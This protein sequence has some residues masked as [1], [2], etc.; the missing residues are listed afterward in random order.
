MEQLIRWHEQGYHVLLQSVG[1]EWVLVID[2]EPINYPRPNAGESREQLR[3]V[4]PVLPTPGA[5]VVAA[6]ARVLP[7][8]RR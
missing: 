7:E 2:T 4:S 1:L 6:L 3:Y 5:C 8:V